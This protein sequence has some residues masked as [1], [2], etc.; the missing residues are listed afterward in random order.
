MTNRTHETICNAIC[1]ANALLAVAALV[2][3]GLF[4]TGA[5]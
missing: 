5:L 3:F 1:C 4:V 2:M